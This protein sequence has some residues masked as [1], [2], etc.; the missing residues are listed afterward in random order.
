MTEYSTQL[1]AILYS[2]Y[3]YGTLQNPFVF[4]K[5]RHHPARASIAC[6]ADVVLAMARRPSATPIHSYT[7]AQLYYQNDA[8]R[9]TKSSLSAP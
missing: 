6:C 2:Q 1:I 5:W 3:T 4:L 8:T 9:I 7:S